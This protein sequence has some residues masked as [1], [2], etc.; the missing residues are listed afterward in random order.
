MGARFFGWTERFGAEL[1]IPC[2]IVASA[3]ALRYIYGM[4]TRLHVDVMVDALDK[5]R[6]IFDLS[7]TEL[8]ELFAVSRQAISHWR[9]HGIPPHRAADVDR[10][11]ELAQ[12]LAREF[13]PERLPQI[14]RTRGLNADDSLA[15]HSFLEVLRTQGVM[16]IYRHL[17][18]LFA[19]TGG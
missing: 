14:V 9:V 4:A 18:Q 10:V 5:I 1:H 3:V 12:Y 11:A 8:G 19:Y 7:E 17:E 6:G 2:G 16:P 15:G 13:M